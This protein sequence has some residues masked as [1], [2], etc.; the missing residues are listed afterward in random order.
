MGELQH[1]YLYLLG[2]NDPT[3]S[4]GASA[5]TGRQGGNRKVRGHGKK[6]GNP[7]YRPVPASGHHNMGNR[8]FTRRQA[9]TVK[10]LRKAAM[11]THGLCRRLKPTFGLE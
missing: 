4:H 1:Y 11:S 6:D 3:K 2:L 7:V 8:N 10:N 9:G 5:G